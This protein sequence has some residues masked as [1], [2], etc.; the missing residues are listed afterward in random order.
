[1]YLG[2]DVVSWGGGGGGKGWVGAAETAVLQM[3][4]VY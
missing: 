2:M 3:P 1:M 4:W